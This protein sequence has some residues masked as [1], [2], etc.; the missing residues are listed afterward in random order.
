VIP[1]SI[2]GLLGT[3]FES[4]KERAFAAHKMCQALSGFAL[5]MSAPYLCTRVK[6]LIVV[7]VLLLAAAGYIALEVVIRVHTEKDRPAIEELV[8]SAEEGKEGEVS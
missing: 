8:V 5:F 2:A 1:V 3:L 6:I 7:G 4:N